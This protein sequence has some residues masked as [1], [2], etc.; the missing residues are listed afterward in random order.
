MHA[1]AHGLLNLIPLVWLVQ[2]G[3]NFF[4]AL[5]VLLAFSGLLRGNIDGTAFDFSFGLFW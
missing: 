3:F 5:H 2:S 1:S 4:F